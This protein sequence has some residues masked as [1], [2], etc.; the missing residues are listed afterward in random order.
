MFGRLITLVQS[1]TSLSR[2]DTST[3]TLSLAL[4]L[5]LPSILPHA[6]A[7]VRDISPSIPRRCGSD[8]IADLS[9]DV[10]VPR[11]HPPPYHLSLRQANVLEKVNP[12]SPTPSLSSPRL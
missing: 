4:P 8:G 7:K 6:P 2:L 10:P 11:M 1:S 9:I 12:P 5:I 3:S